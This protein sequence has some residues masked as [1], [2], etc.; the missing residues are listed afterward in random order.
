MSDL[1]PLVAAA[2]QDNVAVEAAKEISALRKER[3]DAHKVEV[4]RAKNNGND[5]D[6]DDPVVVYA[7]APFESGEYGVNTNMWQV[8]LQNADDAT[9]KLADLR[10]CHIC[11]G[12]GFPVASLDDRLGNTF[13]EGWLDGAPD[14][15]SEAENSDGDVCWVRIC[16]TPYSTWLVMWIRGWPREEWEAKIQADDLNPDEFIGYLVDEVAVRYPDAAVQFKEVSFVAK[17]I[18]GALKRL[19]PAEQNAEVRADRDERISNAGFVDFVSQK[20]RDRGIDAGPELFEQQLDCVMAFLSAVELTERGNNY[21]YD[22]SISEVVAITTGM[23]ERFGG[24]EGVYA[25]AERA[26]ASLRNPREAQEEG[27]EEEDTGEIAGEEE[28]EP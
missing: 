12:G 5:E 8:A 11:V 17:S 2:L 25:A 18:H 19:L 6:E 21:E 15:G 24:V 14:E 27:E 3:E 20:M 10:D 22:A 1:L 23:I 26:V 28:E 4:L 13:R 9:C 7:S 16:F